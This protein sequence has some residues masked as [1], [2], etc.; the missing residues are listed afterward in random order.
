MT[1]FRAAKAQ[2]KARDEAAIASGA[3]TRQQLAREN[4]VLAHW[5][6]DDI[7]ILTYI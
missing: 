4:S 1:P 7:L 3:K 2:D 5:D 6:P